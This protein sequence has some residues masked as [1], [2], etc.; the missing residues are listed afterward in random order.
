M[1]NIIGEMRI[2]TTVRWQY[3]PISKAKMKTSDTTKCWQETTETLDHS[4]ITAG[5]VK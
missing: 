3:I 2:K 4:H 1:F 5:D